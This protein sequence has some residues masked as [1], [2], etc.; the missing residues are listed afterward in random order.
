MYSCELNFDFQ[1]QTDVIQCDLPKDS[2]RVFDKT[3]FARATA[4]SATLEKDFQ[5]YVKQR[6]QHMPDAPV[7]MDYHVKVVARPKGRPGNSKVLKALI[8]IVL[9]Q[10]GAT[11]TQTACREEISQR[12]P[13]F[14]V[15]KDWT[16][17][18]PG[19][20]L[21]HAKKQIQMSA[22][23]LSTLTL[24]KGSSLR[25]LHNAAKVAC[26]KSTP[27]AYSVKALITVT[28]DSVLINGSA[29]KITQNKSNG[30]SYSLVRVAL[31]ALMKALTA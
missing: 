26:S 20:A 21:L 22:P 10:G 2:K 7:G 15:Y 8:D 23:P 17:E 14:G 25:D 18:L 13:K 4:V 6:L 3:Q 19:W 31:P 27:D 1:P 11:L 29:F 30:K 28:A 16:K 9:S 5:S 12:F 24:R